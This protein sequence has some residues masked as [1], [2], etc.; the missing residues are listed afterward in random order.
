MPK[1]ACSC[2]FENKKIV[3]DIIYVT[4]GI[5]MFAKK[6]EKIQS[7]SF[8]SNIVFSSYICIQ[9]YMQYIVQA[10]WIYILYVSTC[11]FSVLSL[12]DLHFD[13]FLELGDSLK[14]FF[15]SEMREAVIPYLCEVENFRQH[16]DGAD[17]LLPYHAPEIVDSFLCGSLCYNIG[18]WF[19]QTLAR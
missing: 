8:S 16:Y 19:Q 4:A 18:V 10:K 2:K 7:S 11:T 15:F 1:I 3:S 5:A 17:L 12:M 6:E 13:E 14:I 9:L